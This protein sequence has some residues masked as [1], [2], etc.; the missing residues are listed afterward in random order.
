MDQN[1]KDILKQFKDS[2]LGFEIPDGYFEKFE[3]Q[4]KNEDSEDTSA[5]PKKLKTGFDVPDGYFDSLDLDLPVENEK[6]LFRLAHPKLRILSLSVAASI[7][8]FFGIRTLNISENS[9]DLTE[10][11]NEDIA[12]W[13]DS[14]LIDF[15]SY[16]IADAFSDIELEESLMN[17]EDLSVYF[18]EIDVENL[19]IEN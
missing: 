2:G 9:T 19:M 18:E 14:G 15:E 13:I 5:I 11:K 1:K 7:L 10:L 3:I 6:K 4:L 17:E 16:E 12:A 8:L